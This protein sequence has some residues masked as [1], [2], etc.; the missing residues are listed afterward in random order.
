MI[1]FHS[2]ILTFL[3]TIV[4]YL[5][6]SLIGFVYISS[7][8]S[9]FFASTQS[10][11]WPTDGELHEWNI[12]DD[13]YL[14]LLIEIWFHLCQCFKLHF[15]EAPF[16]LCFLK[17][18]IFHIVPF[19]WRVTGYLFWLVSKKCFVLVMYSLSQTLHQTVLCQSENLVHVK[20]LLGHTWDP[21]ESSWHF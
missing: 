14:T 21:A 17:L 20:W 2:F 4:T 15:R 6:S 3:H 12:I 1:T 5:I 19:I 13:S 7:L 8:H 16:K 11:Q 9:L 10:R 18:I